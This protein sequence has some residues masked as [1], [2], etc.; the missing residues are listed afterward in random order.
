MK[1]CEIQ[2][3]AQAC[4]PTHMPSAAAIETTRQQSAEL[5]SAAKLTWPALLRL[6]EAN[7]HVYAI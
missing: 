6:L 3:R 5:G 1:A 4:G 2:V 7:G